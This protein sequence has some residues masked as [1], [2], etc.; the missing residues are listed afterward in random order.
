M[1]TAESYGTEEA[2]GHAIKEVR[3]K[4][5]AGHQGITGA[6]RRDDVL[7]AADGSLTRLA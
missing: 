6:L 1:D 2:V 7:K 4:V 3:D 5:A